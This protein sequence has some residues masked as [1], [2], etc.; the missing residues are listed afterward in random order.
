MKKSVI[1]TFVALLSI[2]V[3]CSKNGDTSSLVGEWEYSNYKNSDNYEMDSY[4]FQS[5]SVFKSHHRGRS[6]DGE[7]EHA[8][9]HHDYY[10]VGTY[11]FR[12]G[13]LSL[14]V[15]YDIDGDNGKQTSVNKTLTF[16]VETS[17]VSSSTK[18][19]KVYNNQKKRR[20]EWNR[21]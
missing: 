7:V 6:W 5:G 16:K 21:D 10:Y 3:S 12:N 17:S 9:G 14:K 2:V 18:T 11:S 4:E 19:I 8:I 15:Q 20:E 13:T 1:L